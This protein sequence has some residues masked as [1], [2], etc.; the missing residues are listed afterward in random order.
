[1]VYSYQHQTLKVM[2]TIFTLFGLI[3]ILSFS[4]CFITDEGPIGPVGPRGP[5]GP[6]GPEGP[7]GAPGESGYLFEYENVDFTDPDYEV[8]LPFPDDFETLSTDVVLVYFLWG[9]EDIDGQ[10]VDIWRPL[11][12]LILTDNGLLQYNFD[13]TL[14]DVKLMLTADFSYDLL[15]PIDTD[16]WIVRVVVVPSE[17]W[18]N[19]GRID[20]SNYEAV[21]NLLGLPELNKERK[22]IE[23]R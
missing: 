3:A 23:R 15:E 1:M 18:N 14:Y 20:V 9:T 12:Q 4:S 5:S 13:F 2:K 6:Q 16:D 10:Q 8:F 19:S 22:E 11:P 17:D 7:Q 21:K